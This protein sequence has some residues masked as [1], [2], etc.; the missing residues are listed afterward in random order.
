M[1]SYPNWSLLPK[2]ASGNWL[3]KYITLRLLVSVHRGHV[4]HCKS[5]QWLGAHDCRQQPHRHP[6][7][8]VQPLMDL[9]DRIKLSSSTRSTTYSLLSTSLLSSTLPSPNPILQ[10]H[11]KYG[12]IRAQ[13]PCIPLHCRCL[14]PQPRPARLLLRQNDVRVQVHRHQRNPAHQPRHPQDPSPSRNLGYAGASTGRP[15][16]RPRGLPSVCC[17]HGTYLA[18]HTANAT[19][20]SATPFPFPVNYCFAHAN[21]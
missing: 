16:E 8:L 18:K 4:V 5:E 3:A 6:L 20:R 9:E 11:L 14:G 13:K 21:T 17:L 7:S 2:Q 10:P 15:L 12:R 19:L 1:H